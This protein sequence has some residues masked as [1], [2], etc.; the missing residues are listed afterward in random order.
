MKTKLA[1]AVLCVLGSI[2]RQG[3]AQEPPAPS[4]P[5]DRAASLRADLERGPRSQQADALAAETAPATRL[6]FF[7][8]QPGVT[9]HYAKLARPNPDFVPTEWTRLCL[10]ECETT[11]P[12]GSYRLALSLGA[13]EPVMAPQL[14]EPGQARRLEGL[15]SD[16]SN[17]RLA[18]WL[19]MG[20]GG[21]SSLASMTM[22]AVLANDDRNERLGV[23]TLAGGA[24]G[25]A[26]SLLFGIPLAA[27]A[28]EVAVVHG[29]FP[30]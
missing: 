10:A 11:L 7:T 18:G 23:A 17:R 4:T 21:V 2:A 9:F 6:R 14:F 15:Y 5:V 16:R 24:A 29:N 1:A 26:L 8:N 30:H 20:L 28:D 27:S 22:G 12:P 3:V 13:G 19:I 25:L